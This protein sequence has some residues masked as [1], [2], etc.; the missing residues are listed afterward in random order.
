MTKLIS[1]AQIGEVKMG[2]LGF[3]KR[4][5][6]TYPEAGYPDSQFSVSV[7][8]LGKFVENSTKLTFLEIVFYRIKYRTSCE[9]WSKGL[10]TV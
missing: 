1:L 9:A 8:P 4:W 10:D 7:W 6:S 5:N 3:L 2:I